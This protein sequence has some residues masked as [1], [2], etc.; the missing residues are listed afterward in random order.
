M[1]APP[2][3]KTP[4]DIDHEILYYRLS[5]WSVRKI[6]QK[7]HT[8]AHRIHDVVA[9]YCQGISLPHVRGS[10]P[11]VS[12]DLAEKLM[13]LAQPDRPMSRLMLR[14][15]IHA[16]TGVLVPLK[17][18]A[19]QPR[20]VPSDTWTLKED[21]DLLRIRQENANKS[22]ASLMDRF[23]GRTMTCVRNRWRLLTA[24]GLNVGNEE[25]GDPLKDAESE[26]APQ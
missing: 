21:A 20:V 1:T 25:H 8:G 11:K 3:Q 2:P 7:T 24:Q 13:S 14:E 16:R 4:L 19:D 15:V 22:W 6:A 17:Y 26:A 18:L 9:A 5:G 12:A 23:P 10:P